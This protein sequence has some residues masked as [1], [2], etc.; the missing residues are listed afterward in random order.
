MSS[1]DYDDPTLDPERKRRPAPSADLFAVATDANAEGRAAL[2]RAVAVDR[3]GLL[4]ADGL[5]AFGR[6]AAV[7]AGG[8]LAGMGADYARELLEAAI[9]RNMGGLADV[10]ARAVTL[11]ADEAVK[12]LG[13][14][15]GP[16]L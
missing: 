3:V 1:G 8:P 9:R 4:L 7:T 6:S 12:R 2:A 13:L 14:G 5:F 15:D 10:T 11:G 16:R